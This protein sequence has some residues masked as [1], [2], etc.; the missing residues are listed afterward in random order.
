[1]LTLIR[2]PESD[3]FRSFACGT[4]SRLLPGRIIISAGFL[5]PVGFFGSEGFMGSPF[6]KSGLWPRIADLATY[7]G[8]TAL[9]ILTGTP[10]KAGAD[11]QSSAS[12]C[13]N[14]SPTTFNPACVAQL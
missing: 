2:T 10:D 13:R 4:A 5:G 11:S 3:F 14:V 8:L 9:A 7:L 6:G 1:M 12:N